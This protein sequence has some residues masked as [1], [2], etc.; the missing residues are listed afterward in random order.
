MKSKHAGEFWVGSFEKMGDPVQGT[1]ASAP[2]RVTQRYAAFLIGG[3]PTDARGGNARGG[4]AHGFDASS[5]ARSVLGRTAAAAEPFCVIK[6]SITRYR[7]TLEAFRV[8]GTIT[9]RNDSPQ[10]RWLNRRQ[11]AR[12]PF[13]SAHR[14]ILERLRAQ[15]S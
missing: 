11:M 4:N 3:G 2:F 12:L 8:G 1:L 13:T 10:S 9:G 5:L 15:D 7:I 14:K 6:H